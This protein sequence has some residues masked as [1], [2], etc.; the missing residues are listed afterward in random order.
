[1]HPKL[2]PLLRAFALR[3]R[4]FVGGGLPPGL[5]RRLDASASSDLQLGT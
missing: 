2:T 4:Q 5:T 3:A 1:V